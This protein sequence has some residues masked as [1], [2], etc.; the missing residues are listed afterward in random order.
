ME[1]TINLVAMDVDQR[2]VESGKLLDMKYKVCVLASYTW[3]EYKL[4]FS[5]SLSIFNTGLLVL[6][7]GSGGDKKAD[8]K[9]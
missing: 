9:T 2:Q 8:H 6:S 1:T 3:T 7:R 5:W 4:A